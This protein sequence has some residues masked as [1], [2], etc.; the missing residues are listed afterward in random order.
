MNHIINPMLCEQLIQKLWRQIIRNPRQNFVNPFNTLHQLQT[1]LLVQQRRPFAPQNLFIW[2]QPH[3]QLIS[4][5]PCLPQRIRMSIVHQIKTSI[6]IYPNRSISPATLRML[7]QNFAK[8]PSHSP[9]PVLVT[10]RNIRIITLFEQIPQPSTRSSEC[11]RS[12]GYFKCFNH[13]IPAKIPCTPLHNGMM[14][15]PC[16]RG[17]SL[18]TQTHLRIPSTCLLFI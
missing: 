4:K 8:I 16:Q 11:R 9:R 3:H 15:Q 12:K 6:H 13:W 7:C 5:T 18:S 10:Q 2:H 1:L 17:L 14:Q